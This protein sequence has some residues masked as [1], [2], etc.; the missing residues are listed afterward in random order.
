MQFVSIILLCQSQ[1]AV[2]N[3]VL[4]EDVMKATF[5]KPIFCVKTG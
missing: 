1:Q 3:D 2:I 5:V 4:E